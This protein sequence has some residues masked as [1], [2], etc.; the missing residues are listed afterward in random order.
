MDERKKFANAFSI[1]SITFSS[2]LGSKSE[3]KS[4]G[5]CPKDII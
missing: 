3:R 1:R 2:A 5:K 4:G